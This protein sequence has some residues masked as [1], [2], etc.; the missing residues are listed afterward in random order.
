[1]GSPEAIAQAKGSARIPG[2]IVKARRGMF[3][4]PLRFGF[5]AMEDERPG[6]LCFQPP[7]LYN[8]LRHASVLSGCAEASP[9]K[10]QY[11]GHQAKSTTETPSCAASLCAAFP[12]SAPQP[13]DEQPSAQVSQTF[14]NESDRLRSSA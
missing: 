13:Q 9:G 14:L 5:G 7:K 1:M 6:V 12:K 11:R 3:L 8:R 2:G 10:E 4:K